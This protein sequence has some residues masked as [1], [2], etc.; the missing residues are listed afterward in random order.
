MMVLHF[1][2]T[3]YRFCFTG[4]QAADTIATTVRLRHAREWARACRVS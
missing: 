3:R 1:A 4:M 2:D